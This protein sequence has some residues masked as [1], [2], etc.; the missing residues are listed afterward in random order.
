MSHADHA[1][2]EQSPRRD[3]LLPHMAQRSLSVC[4]DQ[5]ALGWEKETRNARVARWIVFQH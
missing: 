2:V 4:G 5:E 1:Q 3:L